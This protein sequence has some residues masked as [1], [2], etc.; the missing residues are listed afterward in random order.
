MFNLG[1]ARQFKNNWFAQINNRILLDM[2]KNPDSNTRTAHELRDYWR[3]D[4]NVTKKYNKHWNLFEN[5][6]NLLNRNNQYPSR[7]NDADQDN[8]ID[9]IQDEEI[10]LDIGFR[11]KF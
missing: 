5:I 7:T 2:K 11:Y 9:E 1:V 4:I 8:F 10:S 3:V 6:R